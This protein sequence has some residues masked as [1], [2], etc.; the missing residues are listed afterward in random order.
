MSLS[1]PINPPTINPGISKPV[2]SGAQLGTLSNLTQVNQLHGLSP[3][4][5]IG[6]GIPKQVSNVQVSIANAQTG[7]TCTIT[8][9]FR[10]DSS[11]KAF[12]GVNIWV[13]GYQGNGQ[14][15]QVSSGTESPTKFV[16]NNTGE[17]VSFTIQAF[18]NGGNAPI[19]QAPTSSGVLPKS[20][21]GGFGSS[22]TNYYSVNNPPPTTSAV[23]FGTAGQG[24][25]WG[26]GITSHPHSFVSD[27]SGSSAIVTTNNEVRVRQFILETAWTIRNVTSQASSGAAAARTWNI[28]IYDASKN[29]LLDSGA[30]DGSILTVQTK[31]PAAVILPP[32]TYY[33]AQ[34]CSTS[35]LQLWALGNGAQLVTL[36]NMFNAAAPRVAIAANPCVAGVLP[37]TLGVLTAEVLATATATAVAFFEP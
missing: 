29:L 34:T 13:K 36:D 17:T 25:F 15:V 4:N 20:T 28:G 7:A 30:F 19:T 16:L 12:S 35:A 1:Q 11:D 26:P 18:G 21:T 37:A 2:S 14:L 24:G 8:V 23:S 3:N 33:Y 5:A 32:G 10:R 9:L 22:T 31:T 27:V 6:S